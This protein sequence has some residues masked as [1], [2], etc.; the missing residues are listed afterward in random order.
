MQSSM[1]V[2]AEFNAQLEANERR[3]EELTVEV[4]LYRAKSGGRDQV[5]VDAT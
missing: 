4:A 5:A 1:Q 3:L 2:E